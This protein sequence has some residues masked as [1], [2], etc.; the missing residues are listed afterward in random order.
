MDFLHEGEIK[1]VLKYMGFMKKSNDKMIV[2]KLRFKS[3][4]YSAVTYFKYHQ[5][6][7]QETAS[8]SYSNLNNGQKHIIS[9]VIW[10]I[11][12]KNSPIRSWL[13]KI[14]G[15]NMRP[16]PEQCSTL[17]NGLG[18]ALKYFIHLPNIERC[19]TAGAQRGPRML[20]TWFCT[21][22]E[23]S[24]KKKEC[25]LSARHLTRESH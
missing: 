3:G 23:N 7:F 24:W 22:F 9:S 6:H 12:W 19:S 8:A 1:G 15:S 4:Q 16:R 17:N 2:K 11:F 21:S 13:Y 5:I 10:Q 25:L 20:L 18:G 14:G